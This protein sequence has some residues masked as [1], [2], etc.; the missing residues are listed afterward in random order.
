MESTSVNTSI[1]KVKTVDGEEFNVPMNVLK[2]SKY[3]SDFLEDGNS[4]DEVLD[5]SAF[6][7][8]NKEMFAA[9]IEFSNLIINSRV[10]KINKPIQH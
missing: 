7:I 10:P 5:I 2:V 1:V 6:T 4:P 3:F 9:V 8:V